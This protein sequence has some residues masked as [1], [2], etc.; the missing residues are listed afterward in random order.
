MY[1]HADA[2]SLLNATYWQRT[3]HGV[4]DKTIPGVIL[5]GNL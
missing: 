5:P 3:Q 1:N 4:P 2:Q